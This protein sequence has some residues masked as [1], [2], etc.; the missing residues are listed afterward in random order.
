MEQYITDRLDFTTG[1]PVMGDTGDMEQWITDRLDHVTYN[2]V[3]E[4]R[5][6]H[7]TRRR[8]PLWIGIG[9]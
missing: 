6:P 1:C 3:E 9:I 7:I 8:R 5:M 2:K 4:V